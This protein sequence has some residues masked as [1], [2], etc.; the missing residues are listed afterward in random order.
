MLTKKMGEKLWL[1]ELPNGTVW[2]A[3]CEDEAA[4]KSFDPYDGKD[5]IMRVCVAAGF[6]RSGELRDLADRLVR[7]SLEIELRFFTPESP[8]DPRGITQGARIV[9]RHSPKR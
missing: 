5:S 3:A 7:A 6:G 9:P 1:V 2:L 8:V 4:A